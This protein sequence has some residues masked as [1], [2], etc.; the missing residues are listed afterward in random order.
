MLPIIYTPNAE[1]YFRKLKDRKL[2]EHYLEAI[3]L[4]RSNPLIG[5]VKSGDLKGI[6][7]YDIYHNRTNYEI[8]YKITQMDD[9]KL[10]LV[11]MAGTRENFYQ[12]IKKYLK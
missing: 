7:C 9:G 10:I 11:I 6:F 2:K 1:K 8:A 5:Q 3:N 4:I 12:E